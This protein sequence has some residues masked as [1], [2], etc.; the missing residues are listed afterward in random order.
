LPGNHVEQLVTYLA[1]APLYCCRVLIRRVRGLNHV[2][3]AF[4]TSGPVQVAVQEE[5]FCFLTMWIWSVNHETQDSHK[6]VS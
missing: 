6:S 3:L 5:D 4:E 1:V 2:M